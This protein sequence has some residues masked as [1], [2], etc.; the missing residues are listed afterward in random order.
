MKILLSLLTIVV[1]FASEPVVRQFDHRSLRHP[2]SSA[3]TR[4]LDKTKVLL[5]MMAREDIVE[6]PEP[7][8]HNAF[9]ST[10]MSTIV[11][12]ILGA[13]GG[14]IVIAGGAYVV[15]R[16]RKW[17]P[18][19]KPATVRR[20]SVNETPETQNLVNPGF[21]VPVTPGTPV[22]ASGQTVRR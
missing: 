16:Y 10:G 20:G 18:R 12:G 15:Y 21:G 9:E 7:D 4:L 1:A 14:I 11:I 8:Q 6:L 19:T 2:S 22:S 5:G 3:A 13:L 17:K